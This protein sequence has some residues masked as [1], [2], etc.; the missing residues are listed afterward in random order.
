MYMMQK[1]GKTQKPY[2]I[3]NKSSFHPS[4][5]GPPKVSTVTSLLHA[6][7]RYYRHMQANIWH[8]PIF[9]EHS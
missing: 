3:K 7:L 5:L 1:H 4:S 2:L 9:L 6:L 8:I